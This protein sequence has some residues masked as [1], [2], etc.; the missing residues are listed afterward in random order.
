MQVKSSRSLSSLF[1]CVVFLFT[2]FCGVKPAV[3]QTN[4]ALTIVTNPPQGGTATGGGSYAPGT[5]VNVDISANTGWYAEDVLLN[6]LEADNFRFMTAVNE[7][8]AL[9]QGIPFDPTLMTTDSEQVTMG[10][11]NLVT[12][13]FGPLSPT[14]SPGATQD[15]VLAGTGVSFSPSVV[16]RLPL[17]YEWH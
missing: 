4:Y 14:F 10:G 1:C 17:T 12:V 8:S 5:K 11:D 16:G 6:T 2:C 13:T 3:A 7:Q 9:L 15:V